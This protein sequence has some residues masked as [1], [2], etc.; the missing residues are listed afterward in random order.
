MRAQDAAE[1]APNSTLDL[2]RVRATDNKYLLYTSKR[3]TFECPIEQG[4][5][6]NWK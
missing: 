2:L 1:N 5:I 3:K 4:R 6:A